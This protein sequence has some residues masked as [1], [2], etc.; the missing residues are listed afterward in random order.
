M[1]K[2][3]VV[4]FYAPQC[5]SEINV[6]MMKS[7]TDELLNDAERH[8]YERHAEI[9]YCQRDQEIISDATNSHNNG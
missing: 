9:G 7:L 2:K 4:C 6:T 1:T 5:I 3:F 8:H